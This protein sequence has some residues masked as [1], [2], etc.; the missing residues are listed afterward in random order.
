VSELEEAWAAVHD[1]LPAG[2]TVG[3][4]EALCDL[5]ALLGDWQVE[6]VEVELTGGCDRITRPSSAARSLSS[7][8]VS[9]GQRR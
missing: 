2:W 4:A 5:A 6:E 1:A 8:P 3:Q 9:V 7:V